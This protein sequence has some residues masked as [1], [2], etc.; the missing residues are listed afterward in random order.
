MDKPLQQRPGTKF[1][2]AIAESFLYHNRTSTSWIIAYD[3]KVTI[4]KDGHLSINGISLKCFDYFQERSCDALIQLTDCARFIRSHSVFE[5]TN[6][7]VTVAG[8]APFASRGC[9]PSIEGERFISSPI[10]SGSTYSSSL[11]SA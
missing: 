4:I 6:P 8:Y 10:H 7:M 9:Q 11:A 1:P 2:F 3:F 5:K